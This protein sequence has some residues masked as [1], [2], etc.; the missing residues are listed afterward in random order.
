VTIRQLHPERC[1]GKH[2]GYGTFNL[3]NIV[4]RHKYNYL[5][6]FICLA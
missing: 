2:L 6:R 4:F 5:S 1:T 3:N